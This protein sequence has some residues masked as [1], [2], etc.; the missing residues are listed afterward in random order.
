MKLRELKNNEQEISFNL[1]TDSDFSP[2]EALGYCRINGNQVTIE[3]G[4]LISLCE[5]MYSWFKDDSLM[6]REYDELGLF[7]DGGDDLDYGTAYVEETL[8]KNGIIPEEIEL[9]KE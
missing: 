6:M 3:K 2:Y 1:H 7:H 5:K 4:E 9:E 8:I